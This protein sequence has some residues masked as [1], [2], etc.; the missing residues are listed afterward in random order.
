MQS[1]KIHNMVRGEGVSRRNREVARE[2]AQV[3][4][5]TPAELQDSAK[6]VTDRV[7]GQIAA[8]AIILLTEPALL[9]ERLTADALF[10]ENS[11]RITV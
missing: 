7:M 1:V 4:G 11:G 2:L 9:G 5:L 3:G 10:Q 8:E 6:R